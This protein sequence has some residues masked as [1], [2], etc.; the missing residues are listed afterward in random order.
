MNFAD[1]KSFLDQKHDQY[2]R[3]EFI[4]TDP[5][6]VAHTF[7]RKED[8]E[9]MAFLSSQIAW[10]NRTAIIKSAEKIKSLLKNN[11]YEYLT[12][13]KEKDFPDSF[14]FV[15]RTFNGIDLNYF[16]KALRHIYL[17]Y[18]GLESVFNQGFAV[19][20]SIPS[21]LKHFRSVFFELP[22]PV[23]TGKHIADVGK[24]S[25][26]KRLNLFLMWMVRNDKRGVHFGLWNKIPTCKLLIPLDVHVGNTARMLG[27]L[28][29]KQNDLKSVIELT[30][31]LKAFDPNDPVKYDF[32]L[33]GAGVFEGF[34]KDL[35]H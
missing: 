31:N 32:A 35:S 19:D 7:K 9:I 24:L 20:N 29:R 4:E 21:A 18:G 34:G 28:N 3:P 33:F 11:P 25:S 30:D 26:A 8:I 1:L 12:G 10:G 16:L 5:I 27:L 23:R 14:Q 13:S 2:N 15:H 6:Q 17:Q 22:G